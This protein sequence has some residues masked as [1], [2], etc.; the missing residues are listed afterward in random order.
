MYLQFVH[1]WVNKWNNSHLWWN[2]EISF[3]TNLSF[4]YRV[5]TQFWTLHCSILV[6]PETNIRL[7]WKPWHTMKGFSGIL[8]CFWMDVL[9]VCSLRKWRFV[10]FSL[11]QF[12]TKRQLDKTVN[13][14]KRQL[15]KLYINGHTVLYL[16]LSLF[17]RPFI[18][19]SAGICYWQQWSMCRS[20]NSTHMWSWFTY[21]SWDW[22]N[23]WLCSWFWTKIL[24]SFPCVQP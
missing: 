21:F 5:S 16:F 3:K 15:D 4:V 8:P 17:C 7:F 6:S 19:F 24:L 22:R 18:S 23:Y 9:H 2:T 20:F 13:W 10:Q 1:V 11:C 12:W 14:T